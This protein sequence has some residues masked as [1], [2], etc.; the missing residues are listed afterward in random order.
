MLRLFCENYRKWRAVL[1]SYM[2]MDVQSAKTEFIR[3]FYGGQ[4][5]CDIPWLRK[6][7]AEAQTAATMILQHPSSSQWS[8][9]YLNRANPEFSQLCSILSFQEASLLETFLN[10]PDIDMQ[11]AIFDGGYVA[12]SSLFH[13]IV[14]RDVSAKMALEMVIKEEF[15]NLSAT[16]QLLRCGSAETSMSR[17]FADHAG[18]NCLLASLAMMLPENDVHALLHASANRT[19]VGISADEFNSLCIGASQDENCVWELQAMPFEQMR[20]VCGDSDQEHFR[21]VFHEEKVMKA[22]YLF[23]FENID[24]ADVCFLAR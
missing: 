7:A 17:M 11:V 15:P 2:K 8:S 21:L 23:K 9:M 3:I 19:E 12:C 22:V 5:R 1:S 6:L 10:H 14:L 18:T 16:R 24:L 20:C 4:P 13:D